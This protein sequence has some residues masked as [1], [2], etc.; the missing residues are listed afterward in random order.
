MVRPPR[1]ACHV[2]ASRSVAQTTQVGARAIWTNDVNVATDEDT[3][4]TEPD[5]ELPSPVFF[6]HDH[7]AQRGGAERVVQTMSDALGGA[8]IHTS[9]YTP[10]RTYGVLQSYSVRPM[11][12]SKLPGIRTNHRWAFPLMAPGFTMLRSDAPVT[13]SSSAGWS[14]G[15]RH[16]GRKVIY[17]HSPPRWLY[18]QSEYLAPSGLVARAVGAM[19]PA[20]RRWDRRAV[21]SADRHLAVSTEI[22][23]RLR[24]IYDV[25][26]EVL[27]PPVTLDGAPIPV[28][29]LPSRYLLVVSR[30]MSY[31][32][33]QHVMAA[34]EQL[35]HHNLVVVGSGPFARTLRE[36]APAN[37]TFLEDLSDGQLV[38]M[39]RNCTA[40]VAAA[41]EDFGLTPLEAAAQG[42]PS[43][44]LRSGGFLDTV[45]DGYTGVLFDTLRASDLVAAIEKCE[46]RTWNPGLLRSHAERFS[47]GHFSARLQA[48]VAEEAAAW[49]DERSDTR[50]SALDP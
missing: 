1:P 8:V 5:R 35:P 16:K 14:H 2:L 20:L 18:Q 45:E 13:V 29:N 41:F 44:A 42:R 9:V 43:I 12:F 17:W 49:R 11:W 40:L 15:V 25:E 39:Y 31:K 27:H 36:R 37:V 21:A 30:L 22:A 10:D 46:A 32:N 50:R 48:V 19:S 6:A 24:R 34:M 28:D 47:A 38:W 4:R 23:N 3:V 7:L 33:V 26:A